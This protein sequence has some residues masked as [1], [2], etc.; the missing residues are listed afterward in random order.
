[1]RNEMNKVIAAVANSY[2]VWGSDL[3]AHIS[4]CFIGAYEGEYDSEGHYREP[5]VY[6]SDDYNSEGEY[7]GSDD[8]EA[9]EDSD[10]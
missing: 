1:M 10:W 2:S 9:D 3:E 5:L 8:D 7:I 6:H 4:R